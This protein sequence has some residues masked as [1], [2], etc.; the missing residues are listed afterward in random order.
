MA[1]I[2][3]AGRKK[4]A[5][6]AP[7]HSADWQGL[8]VSILHRLVVETILG[9]KDLPKA[10]YVH[11]VGEVVESLDAGDIGGRDATGVMSAAG[12]LSLPHSS[13]QPQWNMSARS[14]STAKSCQPRARTSI[15]SYSAGWW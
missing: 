8:G 10:K 1:T 6:I 11:S 3:D 15:R 13:C 7:E 14:A 9:A 12:I 2:T 4:M 5:E